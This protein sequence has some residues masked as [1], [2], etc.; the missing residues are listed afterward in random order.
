MPARGHVDGVWGPAWVSGEGGV[1]STGPRGVGGGGQAP[2]GEPTGA[3][4][5]TVTKEK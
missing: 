3:G 4:G 1:C 5:G 2:A